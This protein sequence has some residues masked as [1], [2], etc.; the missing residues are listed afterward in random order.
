[1]HKDLSKIHIIAAGI[2]S[3]KQAKLSYLGVKH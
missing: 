3:Q 1:M 2:E